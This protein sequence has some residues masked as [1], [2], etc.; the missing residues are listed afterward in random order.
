MKAHLKLPMDTVNHFPMPFSLGSCLNKLPWPIIVK[1]NHFKHKEEIKS[2]N[3]VEEKGNGR[4]KILNQR[5]KYQLK[6][7]QKI[8]NCSNM[9]GYCMTGYCLDLTSKGEKKETLPFISYLLPNRIWLVMS[10]AWAL[11]VWACWLEEMQTSRCAVKS[12]YNHP[13]RLSKLG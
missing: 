12:L 4:H 5:I 2:K 11:V 9:S 13:P 1:F 7:I 10:L 6:M 8:N 3:M